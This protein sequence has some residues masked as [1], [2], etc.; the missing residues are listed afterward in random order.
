M[1]VVLKLAIGTLLMFSALTSHAVIL[2]LSMMT[3]REFLA[4][5]K[6]EIRIIL[7]W[8][9]GYYKDEQG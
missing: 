1:P 3:C 4:T 6:D 9:E 2:D 8:L 5:D 7:A